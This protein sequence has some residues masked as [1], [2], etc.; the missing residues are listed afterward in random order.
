MALDAEGLRDLMD[1]KYAAIN[2]D[3]E[4]D[5]PTRNQLKAGLLLAMAQAI[6]QHIQENAEV[7]FEAGNITGE[8]SNGDTHDDLTATAGTIS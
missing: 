3:Y 5:Q 1:E 7:A 4:A 6:V 8:D 2:E